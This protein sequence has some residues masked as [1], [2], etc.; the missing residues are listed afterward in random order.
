MVLMIVKIIKW[1]QGLYNPMAFSEKV[2]VS[3]SSFFQLG[4]AGWFWGE[5]CWGGVLCQAGSF[6]E[7]L[8]SD[9]EVS[10]MN[11]VYFSLRSFLPVI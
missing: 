2:F 8:G 7:R 3:E 10:M 11:W 4:P 1:P 9:A 6:G 5:P